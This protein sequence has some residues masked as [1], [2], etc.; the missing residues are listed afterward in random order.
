[1][2]LNDGFGCNEG[3]VKEMVVKLGNDYECQDKGVEEVVDENRGISVTKDK[4]DTVEEDKMSQKPVDGCNGSE[5]PV[6]CNVTSVKA[7]SSYASALNACVDNK[8]TLIPIEVGSEGM[9][10]VIFYAEIVKEGRC[11]GKFGLKHIMPNGNGVF[12]F[13]FKY[14]EGIQSVIV[15][16]PWMVN[17]KPMNLPLEAWRT[18]GISAIV[19]RLGTPLIMNPFTTNLCDN[20]TER[21]GFARVLIEVEACKGLANQID[22]LYKNKDNIVTGKKTVKVEYDWKP[23]M[24]SYCTMFGHGVKNCDCRPKTNRK[25]TINNTKQPVKIVEHHQDAKKNIEIYKPI[26]KEKTNGEGSMGKSNQE[27]GVVSGNK[28]DKRSPNGKTGWNVHK[29]VIDSI[30]N[31]ENK[32]FVLVDEFDDEGPKEMNWDKDFGRWSWIDNAQFCD[33]GCRIMVGWDIDKI[34][35]MKMHASDQSMLCL[36]EVISTKERLPCTFIYDATV[37]DVNVSLNIDDHSKG[38]SH[39]SQDT[40]EFH[41]CVNNLKIEDISRNEEFLDVYRRAHVVFLMTNGSIIVGSDQ[42]GHQAAAKEALLSYADKL[43]PISV[44]KVNLRKHD[45]NVPKDADFD[46]WLPPGFHG[47]SMIASKIGNLMMQDS[48]TN[49]MCLESCGMCDY[50]RILIEIDACN[51]FSDNLIIVVPNLVG[52]EYM[53]DTIHVEYVY[54]PP[55]CG[56]GASS[57]ADDEGFAKMKNNK[58]GG[59]GGTKNFKPVSVKPKTQFVPKVNQ[60]NTKTSPKMASSVGKKNVSVLGNSLKTASKMNVST[61]STRIVSL[62][63]SFDAL[64]DDKW[65][66]AEV[67]SISKISTSDM[68]VKWKSFT[69][70]VDKI[71][72]IEKELMEG[73]VCSNDEYDYDPYDDDMYEGQEIPGN[74]H[75]IADNLNIKNHK[76]CLALDASIFHNKITKQN[77]SA[78]IVDVSNEK[79][80][81]AIGD[82]CNEVKD[83]F[84]KGKFLGELNAT[85]ITLVP[86]ITYNILLTQELLNGYDSAK[87]SKRCS[88]KIVMCHWDVNFVKVIKRYL[89]AFSNL[90]GLYPN[91][92]KSIIFRGS[93]DIVSIENVLNILPF[94]RG[95]LLV[96]YLGVPLVAK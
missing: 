45:V 56:N 81:A 15:N 69:P 12:L 51:S 60:T 58:S 37:G 18:K 95:K 85:L 25:K 67:E 57:E 93:M 26:N 62:S 74:L 49:S 10:V 66:I 4:N 27:K 42:V 39:K 90:S 41:D 55:R 8:L 79:I 64:N 70:V 16:G 43:S 31:S 65:D 78:M 48:Y 72:R 92:G 46:I 63:N 96:R 9:E 50:A 76:E 73:N 13:K 35:C 5:E 87:G 29:D 33:R 36:V 44:T 32:L 7:N 17:E 11:G 54:E 61:S 24:C 38:T 86:K 34:H 59:N 28:V 80:K 84:V 52:L 83:F 94:K 88:M 75:D 19:S 6:V 21:A 2:G 89:E 1:M 82:V 68:R 20:G 14:E 3:S 47:L 40:K 30:R 23:H 91:F 22:I 53:K 77:A 71:N